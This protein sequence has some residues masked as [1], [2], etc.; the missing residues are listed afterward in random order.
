MTI[1]F[2]SVV[3]SSYFVFDNCAT[4]PRDKI[5]GSVNG[6]VKFVEDRDSKTYR[7]WIGTYV[8]SETWLKFGIDLLFGNDADKNASFSE[9]MF[10]PEVLM[11]GFQN[12]EI[13][14]AKNQIRKL[15]SDKKVLINKTPEIKT[16]ASFEIL[17]V[18]F[19]IILLIF[20]LVLSIWD[21]F[22]HHHSKIFDSILLTTTGL[23]G[24]LITYMML[25]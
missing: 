12:A 10:L 16:K 2:P 25:Y 1:W 11:N 23:V 19:S 6:Y 13:H 7:Q 15:V 18:T 17:P 21:Y 14:N 3:C 5:L 9:S 4:R 20:G 8:G 24:L 22:R